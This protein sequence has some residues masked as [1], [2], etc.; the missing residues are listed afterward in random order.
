MHPAPGE[1]KHT[2][3]LKNAVIVKEDGSTATTGEYKEGT[4]VK[5]KPR[6]TNSKKVFSRWST[7]PEE[8]EAI[9]PNHDTEGTYTLTMPGYNLSVRAESTYRSYPLNVVGGTL[10]NTFG[11]MV[12]WG[13]Y[14][15]VKA[16]APAGKYFAGLGSN[17]NRY[18]HNSDAP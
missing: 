5:I 1:V 14:V 18:R 10:E 6:S 13:T 8:F 3:T 2:L 12:E 9:V 7:D 16:S 11:N 4:T 17:R 15:A